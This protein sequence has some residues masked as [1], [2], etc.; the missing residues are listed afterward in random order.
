M[1]NQRCLDNRVASTVFADDI[2]NSNIIKDEIIDNVKTLKTRE[3]PSLF[4]G[5]LYMNLKHSYDIDNIRGKT[6]IVPLNI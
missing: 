6:L 4:F 1:K 5:L 3:D 2:G